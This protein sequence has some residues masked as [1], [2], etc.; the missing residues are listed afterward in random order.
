MK[1]YCFVLNKKELCKE[2][3]CPLDSTTMH[4]KHTM[5]R[6]TVEQYLDYQNNFKLKNIG[7][8]IL[9]G[10]FQYGCKNSR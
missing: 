5:K 4:K 7:I 8:Q 6:F 10:S 9:A 1:Q 3:D 2:L